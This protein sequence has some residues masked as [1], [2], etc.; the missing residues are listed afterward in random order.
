[1]AWGY[2]LILDCKD[3]D[4]SQITNPQ[5]LKDFAQYLV[6]EIKM[7][8]Y[9]LPQVVHFGHNETEL[10][11]WT[12]IQ[13]IETSNIIAHFND[14]SNEGYID[15]FSC[16]TFDIETAVAAVELFFRPKN[17]RQTYLERQA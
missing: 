11:G 2:H 17:I 7:T 14:F 13:L 8:A 3:C 5:V 6:N 10:T 12:L 16:K 4:N 9:G 1:M 15:I